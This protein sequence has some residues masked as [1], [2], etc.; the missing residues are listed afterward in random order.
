MQTTNW[1]CDSC[2]R[3]IPATTITLNGISQKIPMRGS[4][5]SKWLR[6][7]N[8]QL[9]LCERCAAK[10]EHTFNQARIEMIA[11]VNSK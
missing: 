2:G 11:E 8:Y 5:H 10:V 9:D 3:T 1:I 7:F 4:L 6:P